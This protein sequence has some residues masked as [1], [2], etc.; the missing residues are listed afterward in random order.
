M[1]PSVL[2]PHLTLSPA[3]A[4]ESAGH[5]W[6]KKGGAG[7]WGP[8]ISFPTAEGIAEKAVILTAT[9]N[10]GCASAPSPCNSFTAL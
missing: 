5:G 4:S 1:P 2:R 3:G 9:A 10:G 7:L 8:L 6:Y